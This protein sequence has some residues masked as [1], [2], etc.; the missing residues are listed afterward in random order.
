[1][2]GLIVPGHGYGWLLHDSCLLLE[3]S[4]TVALSYKVHAI[5]ANI[6][7]LSPLFLHLLVEDFPESASGLGVLHLQLID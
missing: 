5:L 1:M 3:C 2:A 6:L 4:F 7:I